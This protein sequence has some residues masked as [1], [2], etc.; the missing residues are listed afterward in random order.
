MLA[1]HLDYSEH[2]PV[3]VEQLKRKIDEATKLLEKVGTDIHALS[4]RLHSPKLEYLGLAKT[5]ASLCDEMIW[6]GRN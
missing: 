4:H 5:A 1:T 3:A 2:P 6:F